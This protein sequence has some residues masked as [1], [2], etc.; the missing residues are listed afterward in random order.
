MA[1]KDPEKTAEKFFELC[2]RQ[3]NRADD[4][5]LAMLV[6]RLCFELTYTRAFVSWA[7]RNSDLV[8]GEPELI[9]SIKKAMELA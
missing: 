3:Q 1:L 5:F 7:K 2:T 9:E 6:T 8:D 4:V